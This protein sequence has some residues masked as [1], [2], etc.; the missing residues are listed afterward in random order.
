MDDFKSALINAGY[1]CS[2]FHKE[3]AAVKTDAPNEVRE[4]ESKRG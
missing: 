2:A 1:R 3:P 4:R